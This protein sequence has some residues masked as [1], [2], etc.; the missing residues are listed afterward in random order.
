M[1]SLHCGRARRKISLKPHR[2]PSMYLSMELAQR[3][4]AEPEV[5]GCSPDHIF[6]C[7]ESVFMIVWRHETTAQAVEQL[8]ALM[9]RFAARVSQFTLVV[10][11]E[12]GAS[13]PSAALRERIAAGL[14]AA[15]PYIDISAVV[16]EGRG[17]R[18][19][20]VRSVLAGLTLVVRPPYG[21]KV[22]ARVDEASR[23]IGRERR[24]FDSHGL[25]DALATLRSYIPSR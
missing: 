13:V 18:A 8:I 3:L 20:A 14:Q 19:A 16:H 7:W 9:P 25:C 6:G 1:L 12:D 11:V 22:F 10:V 23:W 2:H 17:F 5:L 21:H 4:S 15:A 24:R